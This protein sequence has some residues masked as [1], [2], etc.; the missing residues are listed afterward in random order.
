MVPKSSK[1][2]TIFKVVASDY[3]WRRMIEIKLNVENY[4]YPKS[5]IMNNQVITCY[6]L[7]QVK[8]LMNDALLYVSRI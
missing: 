3:K 6:E 8:I 5:I 1:I 4:D 7:S 2:L